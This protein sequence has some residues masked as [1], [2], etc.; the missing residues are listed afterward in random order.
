MVEESPKKSSGSNRI[1]ERAI[2]VCEGQ[3]RSLKSQLDDRYLVH[4]DVEHPILTWLCEHAAY[5]LNRLEVG[6]DGKT[7]YERSKG[8]RATVLGLE[9]GEKIFWKEKPLGAMRKLVTHCRLGL[10]LGI[11]IGF[12]SGYQAFE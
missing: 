12:I 6:H 11:K 1:V 7:A 3:I 2:Q 8:K 10:F 9:F 5:L 4:I